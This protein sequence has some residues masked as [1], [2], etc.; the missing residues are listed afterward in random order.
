MIENI[1]AEGKQIRKKV[2]RSSQGEFALSKDRPDVLTFIQQSNYDRLPDLVP[3][4]HARMST[5]PFAFYRGTA[6]IMAY[7]LSHTHNTGINVQA[8]GDCHLMN[9]GG[10][11]TPER[12]LV[13]DANDFDETHPAPWEWDIKRL[14]TSFVLA[15]RNN[16]LAE[17][18][19]Q[20]L[21]HALVQSYRKHIFLFSEMTM[22]ELWY[23]K[24]DIATIASK[25]KDEAVRDFL[26]DSI[27]KAHKETPQ[28][29]LYKTTQEVFGKLE[30][31]NQPPLVYHTKDV[32]NDKE[33]MRSFMNYYFDTLQ[34]DRKWLASKYE[35]V[36]VALK[37]V[38]V[39]SVGTRCYVVLLMNDKKEPL[40]LQVKEARQSV[41][42]PYTQPG[43]YLHQGQRVVEGQR[44]VQ[45]ASD[46]FLGWS[47]GPAG[48]HFYL[49]QLRDRKIA[50]TIEH[51][52]KALLMAYARLCGRMLARA[53]AK[54]GNSE[55]ISSYMG[56]SEAFEEAISNFA[57]AYADQTEKD[58]DSFLKA[59]KAGKLP[60]E[61]G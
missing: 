39:G 7:D 3:I 31:T 33:Y 45:A 16:N 23:K 24:F 52:N 38:G 17:I 47:T 32:E 53:H 61:K 37:V 2:S 44:L 22:L 27:A 6:S 4:R 9:F 55:I 13:F 41:L 58:Y 8:I 10:F 50:P 54:T 18:D 28:K 15:G 56:K 20:E 35:I 59:I 11:A 26:D 30:I 12:T 1:V 19:A 43:K 34:H 60:V 46:I 42:E 25:T 51:F 36:D 14:A 29:V 57:I 49:R 21:A 48:R 40:F 5:S